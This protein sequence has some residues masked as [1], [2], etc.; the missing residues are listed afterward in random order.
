MLYSLQYEAIS[1]NVYVQRSILVVVLLLFSATA[2]AAPPTMTSVT[3][4][5]VER[6]QA[7]EIT[8]AGAN[9]TPQSRLVLPF[10]A[11]QSLLPDAKPNP[12]QIRIQL[13]PD[14]AVPI[15]IYPL[16]LITEDGV[17]APFFFSIDSFPT[18]KEVEDNNTFEK[19]QKVPF[20]CVVDGQ[21]PGGDVDNF[22][23]PAKKGQRVVIETLSA[24]LGSAVLPQLRVTDDK[25]R[26]LAA[27]DTQALQGDARVIF[28]AP[29]DGEYVVEL[30]DTR[31]RGGNPPNYRLRIGE[32]D[33]IEEVFPLG[34][35]RG[36]TVAFTLRGGTLSGVQTLERALDEK[37]PSSFMLLPVGDGLKPGTL[38]LRVAIGDLPELLWSK[39]RDR[40]PRSL[41]VLPP[42]TINSRLEKPRESDRFQ[43][44]VT[45]GQR[46]RFVVEAEALGSRLDGVLR[47]FDQN[48][49]QL[50]LVDDVDIPV[51]VPGQPAIKTTDPSLDFIVPDGVSLLIAEVRDQHNRGGINYCYRLTI[52]PATPDFV[53]IQP[54][55][56]INVPRGGSALLSVPVLRRGYAGPIELTIPNLPPGLSVQGGIVPTNATAGLLTLTAAN[57]MAAV[58]D[59]LS[60][61]IEGKAAD[62]KTVIHRLAEHRFAVSRDANPATSSLTWHDFALAVTTAEPFTVAGPAN[63]DVVIGY[64][65]TVA[66]T[67]TRAKDQA[68]LAIQVSGV[69]PVSIP[70]PGQP[71]PPG[72]LVFQP[73]Q[74]ATGDSTTCTVTVPINGPE[75]A[76]DIV[77]QGKAKVGAAERTVTSKAMRLVVHRPF[78]VQL[79]DTAL[80]L[81]PGQTVTL[82]GKIARQAVFK[83]AVQLALAGLPAGVTLAAPPK[84]LM[85]DQTEF[86][87]D[88]KVDAKFI[89]TTPAT[90]NLTC[91]TTINGSAYAHP[92][93]TVMAK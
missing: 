19:A 54:F 74:P 27:D 50:A 9:L 81:T 79:S 60:L 70:T 4:R 87:I 2:Q 82:K 55:S 53:V 45:P 84:P 39:P 17:S 66:T 86:Q 28:T 22:R 56:E 76:L 75:G 21:C 73:S 63:L 58:P 92:L 93:V 32:Y 41:D 36:T 42:L 6:G 24:R 89:A 26:L 71:A 35:R 34:G 13:T 25:Q 10:K 59:S 51:T 23:F 14:A 1:M 18:V 43:F 8:I 44:A 29:T 68:A 80:T 90:L 3:P 69:G 83:E 38:P 78:E 72:P 20:P 11:T 37:L 91:S 52:E 31:Y 15:G 64:P 5:G 57:D 30:S 67:L 7:V 46:W 65:A 61:S 62:G 48:A 88:L 49:K 12:A 47:L 77:L 33:V 40:D 85:G 16:R